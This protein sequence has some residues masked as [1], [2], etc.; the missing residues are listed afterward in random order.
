MQPPTQDVTFQVRNC[1]VQPGCGSQ[2][3]A[4]HNHGD[5]GG[6]QHV[7][8]PGQS[9]DPSDDAMLDSDVIMDVILSSG[10]ED[11]EIE[12]QSPSEMYGF[13]L[14]HLPGNSDEDRHNEDSGCADA[15]LSMT[16]E[17]VPTGIFGL[18]V[19]HQPDDSDE[20]I[21]IGLVV[22]NSLYGSDDEI[23]DRSS[24]LVAP[25]IQSDSGDEIEIRH[26]DQDL[27][28]SAIWAEPGLNEGGASHD[29]WAQAP[30]TLPQVNPVTGQYTTESFSNFPDE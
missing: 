17:D 1:F 3:E 8:E 20:D 11:N 18:V 27:G 21:D 2:S 30:I 14:P 9:A 24:R 29:N 28:A 5:L 26:V 6:S 4:T 15:D 22:A 10:S 12:E 19:P 16:A 13:V 23:V 7:S 25:N